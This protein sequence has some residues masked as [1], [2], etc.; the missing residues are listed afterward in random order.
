[1]VGA[2]EGKELVKACDGLTMELTER[3]SCDVELI[4]GGGFSP[5]EGFMNE[6]TWYVVTPMP[7]AARRDPLLEVNE[8]CFVCETRL[9]RSHAL[10]LWQETRVREHEAARLQ[11]AFRIAGRT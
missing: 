11:P 4:V 7:L 5:I 9:L 3:Q 6:E 2:D 8:A 10:V 1:M